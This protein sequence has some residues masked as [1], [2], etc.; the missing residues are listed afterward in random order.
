MI[1][2]EELAIELY[3][4]QAVKFGEFETKIGLITPI[5]FDLR[6]IISH[7]KLMVSVSI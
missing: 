6:I 1:D 3:N 4:I 2:L 7:P 5:Y